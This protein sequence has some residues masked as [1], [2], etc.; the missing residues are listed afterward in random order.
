MAE[1]DLIPS[2]QAACDALIREKQNMENA[3]KEGALQIKM[4]GKF[5]VQEG[6]KEALERDPEFIKAQK[7]ALEEALKKLIDEERRVN[8]WSTALRE[9][10]TNPGEAKGPQVHEMR[11]HLVIQRGQCLQMFKGNYERQ[12]VWRRSCQ[13]WASFS[14]P[15]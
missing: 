12:P 8:Q 6:N 1:L 4:A 15:N 5:L 7:S 13:I 10:K 9:M 11:I 2:L 3:I 14:K